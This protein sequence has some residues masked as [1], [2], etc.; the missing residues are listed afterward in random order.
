MKSRSRRLLCLTVVVAATT[1][2][3]LAAPSL[4]SAGGVNYVTTT[5]TGQSIVPG[6]TDVGNHC[7]DCA[8]LVDFPFPVTVYGSSYTS[9][10]VTDNGSLQL[11]TS[12]GGALRRRFMPLAINGFDRALIPYLGDLRTDE[13]GDGIFTA[14]TGS[15]PHRQ[16]VIE[17][18]TTYFQRAGTANFEIILPE[19][20]ATLSVIYG[21]TA[22]NGSVETSGIQSSDNGPFT[23]FSC[24]EATLV[25]GLRVNYVPSDCPSG[26]TQIAIGDYFFDPADITV[27]VGTTVC[28]TNTVQITHTAT[29]DTG[30]FDSGS[31]ANGDTFTYTFNNPGSYPYH[32]TVHPFMT[33]TITVSGPPPPRRRLR[34]LRLRRLRRR[35][36]A[37]AT[38]A[39]STSAASAASARCR[40]P[41][42]LGLR[43]AAAKRKI[44]AA[45]C[46][47]GRV[48][49]PRQ[50]ARCE[51][52]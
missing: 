5:Q 3:A 8:T 41:R 28:W 23:Q 25:S 26:S 6:T 52:A 13:S 36:S 14:T 33:G 47:V 46:S 18:R 4:A 22:D 10:Y 43:L 49:R 39:T 48:R 45:H 40:V 34:R 37:T 20:S 42:V 32:C 29:S 44:R 11:L 2:V 21:Q 16:F 50:G 7:D 30:V 24:G 17:W 35:P 15:A 51:V 38:S 27:P 31:L 19:D 1:I 12:N 9:G